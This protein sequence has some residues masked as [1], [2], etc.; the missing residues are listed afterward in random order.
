MGRRIV[1]RSDS[2]CG[3]CV[4]QLLAGVTYE[5]ALAAVFPRKVPEPNR[6]WTSSRQLALALGRFGVKCDRRARPL[7]GKSYRLLEH[8]AI[9]VTDKDPGT[10]CWHWIVWDWKRKRVIDPAKKKKTRWRV[11][12]Y[13]K[14]YRD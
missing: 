3:V 11:T 10:G 5:E 8:D 1:Q 13:L 7:F 9:L 6:R 2:D 12:S 4:V 14:V